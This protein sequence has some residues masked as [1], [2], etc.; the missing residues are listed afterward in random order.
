MKITQEAPSF[1][2]NNVAQRKL[3][4]NAG[5]GR[6]YVKPSEGPLAVVPRVDPD[7]LEHY[8]LRL[9]ETVGVAVAHGVP[10]AERARVAEHHVALRLRDAVADLER[11]APRP[12]RAALEEDALER[13]RAAMPL[14]RD[15]PAVTGPCLRRER[16]V[17]RDA[18]AVLDYHVGAFAHVE[19]VVF[20]QIVN[21]LQSVLLTEGPQMIKTPTWYVFRMFRDHQDAQLVNSCIE[22]KTIGEEEEFMVPNLTES[23]SVDQDGRL[24]ITIGNLSADEAYPVNTHITGFSAKK[25]SAQILTGQMADRNTFDEPDTVKTQPFAVELADGDLSFTI[26][27][28]SVVT[29]TLEQ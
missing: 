20:A 14:R 2:D 13:K 11:G 7:V 25:A 1:S 27:A 28:H 17:A 21:V 18:E 15:L 22:T 10:A 4:G 9:G 26:P 16:V 24:L 23:A 6:R 29:I 3:S 8:A 12:R 19:R 5:F